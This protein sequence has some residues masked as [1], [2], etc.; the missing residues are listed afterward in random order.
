MRG[1]IFFE[2][3]LRPTVL[4]QEG[5]RGQVIVAETGPCQIRIVRDM[6]YKMAK[7]KRHEHSVERHPSAGN[8]LVRIQ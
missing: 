1:S 8:P 6:G 5:L 7:E 4:F 3:F 2:R